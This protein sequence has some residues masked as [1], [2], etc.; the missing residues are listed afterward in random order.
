MATSKRPGQELENCS[1]GKHGKKQEL[2]QAKPQKIGNRFVLLD[3]I[4]SVCGTI[5]VVW[6]SPRPVALFGIFVNLG[7]CSIEVTISGKGKPVTRMIPSR[8]GPQGTEIL[9]HPAATKVTIECLGN[10]RGGDCK[11][12]YLLIW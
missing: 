12:V 6:R 1:C 11:V 5:H 7:I 3:A 2:P 10:V 9:L 4:A 8:A